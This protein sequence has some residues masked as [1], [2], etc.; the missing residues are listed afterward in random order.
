M[1]NDYDEDFKTAHLHSWPA[2]L[3]SMA[4]NIFDRDKPQIMAAAKKYGYSIAGGTKPDREGLKH[5][6]GMVTFIRLN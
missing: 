4:R 2:A 5:Q 6:R 3:H 1:P